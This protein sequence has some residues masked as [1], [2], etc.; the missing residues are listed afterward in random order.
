MVQAS[1]QHRIYQTLGW[2]LLALVVLLLPFWVISTQSIQ[3]GGNTFTLSL[4]NVMHSLSYVVAV[5]GLGLLVGFN[6]QLSLGNSFFIGVGAYISATLVVDNGWGFLRSLIVVLPVTFALGVLFGIPALRIRGLYL[7]LVTLGLAAVFP[8]IVRLEGLSERT[9]G[10]NGKRIPDG[11]AAPEG[12]PLQEF[13]QGLSNIPGIG[14]QFFADGR[15]G[16]RA[17]DE[18]WTYFVLILLTAI[19]IWMVKNLIHSR[20]G[21]AIIAVRDNETGAAVNGVNLPMTKTL[22]FGYSAALGGL[23]G[24]MYAMAIGFVAPD[25]FGVN[26]AIFLIVGLV[27]GGLGTLSG[28]VIGGF[29]IVFVPVWTSQ[30]KE[31][32]GVSERV[33]SGPTATAVLG[34]LLIVLTFVMPGG[35]VYGLRRLRARLI[36]IVPRGMSPAAAAAAGPAAVPVDEAAAVAMMD[37]HS[38]HAS[39]DLQPETETGSVSVTTKQGSADGN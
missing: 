36:T 26:L 34:I 1:R 30:V 37:R 21:R 14:E 18:V 19:A 9:G 27:V 7:A 35:I 25:V 38:G 13:R 29:V 15:L 31:L 10:A 22:T 17:A 23:A 33:L 3:I 6:G 8:A 11:F 39:S 2:L 4:G 16:T 5:L 24:T 20:P 32:P 12:V 28:A